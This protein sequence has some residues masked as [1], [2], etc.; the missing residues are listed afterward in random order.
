M[1]PI[2]ILQ[3]VLW[4]LVGIALIGAAVLGFGWYKSEFAGTPS[5]LSQPVAEI[6]GPFSLVDTNG[7]TVTDKDFEGRP[8]AMFFGFTY[9]PDICPTTLFEM[10]NYLKELGPAGDELAVV[11][12]SVDPE[13]DT[14]EQLKLYLSSFDERIVGLTGTLEQLNPM[15]DAFRV[16]RKKVPLDGGDYTMDHTAAV[17][18]LNRKGEFV[19]T[20][21]FREDAKTALPKLKRL[22]AGS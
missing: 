5:D 9:C 8:R 22:V 13:R 4:G 14:P 7:K 17:Y 16:Y 6:G 11:F 18:L 15:L 3:Y 2:R 19:G 12:T 1:S 20:I 10:S 21:A